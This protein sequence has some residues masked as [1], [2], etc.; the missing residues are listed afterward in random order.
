MDVE[1][2][3]NYS[4][5]VHLCWS[6]DLDTRVLLYAGKRKIQLSKFASK[7]RSF[8]IRLGSTVVVTISASEHLATTRYSI[9]IDTN[10]RDVHHLPK[11]SP[12]TNWVSGTNER[13][14]QH[15][16]F[17]MRGN[18]LKHCKIP[19][20]TAEFVTN[21]HCEGVWDLPPDQLPDAL[22]KA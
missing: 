22:V 7:S 9:N 11:N 5:P 18:W 19:F 15:V 2:R 4:H 20:P 13:S 6:S 12:K 14:S 3:I 10:F 8:W 1:A 16:T 17:V 21:R